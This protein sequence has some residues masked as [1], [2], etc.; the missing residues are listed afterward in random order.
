MW[1]KCRCALSPHPHHLKVSILPLNHVP[2]LFNHSAA[3]FRR[4]L[5]SLL[6]LSTKGLNLST[7]PKI[8][9]LALG[10]SW[11][12]V[13]RL[14]VKMEFNAAALMKCFRIKFMPPCVS[15]RL[16]EL[17]VNNVGSRWMN[18]LGGFQ[19][20]SAA[21][22]QCRKESVSFQMIGELLTSSSKKFEP[23]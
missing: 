1:T 20:T 15:L 22:S 3:P 18:S 17:N 10:I 5:S 8:H 6:H 11:L 14:N 23:C 13:G 16:N 12:G 9:V 7:P 21:T 4:S 2:I 19:I